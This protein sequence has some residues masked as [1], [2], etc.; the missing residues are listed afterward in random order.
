MT[1]RHKPVSELPGMLAGARRAAG[2]SREE[3]AA[4]A[5]MSKDTL[6]AYEQG[7]RAPRSPDVLHRLARALGIEVTPLLDAAGLTAAELLSSLVQRPLAHFD[8][9]VE[10]YPWPC[11]MNNENLEVV[12]GNA[13]VRALAGVDI[14]SLPGPG[15]RHLL[16]LALAEGIGSRLANL[17]EVLQQLARILKADSVDV[18]GGAQGPRFFASLAAW[19]AKEP[20]QTAAWLF[21]LWNEAVPWEIGR[22]VTFRA[23]WKAS[24]GTVLAFNCLITPWSMFVGIWA[25]DWHPADAA[26]WR[27]LAAQETQEGQVRVR[28]DW[29]GMLEDR[30]LTYGLTRQE[31]ADLAGV[32]ESAIYL[33]ERGLRRPTRG[34]LKA[35]IRH[36]AIDG[37]TAAAIAGALDYEP[38]PSNGYRYICG[39]TVTGRPDL[40][41]L[42]PV[43]IGPEDIRAAVAEHPWPCLVVHA[44][45]EV[46]AASGSAQAM[47][48]EVLAGPGPRRIDAIVPGEPFRARCLNWEEASPRL[49]NLPQG[50][51]SAGLTAAAE[52]GTP[53]TSSPRE[54]RAYTRFGWRDGGDRWFNCVVSSW[55]IWDPF[56]AFDFHPADAATWEWLGQAPVVR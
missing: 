2:L 3:L 30:R 7:R 50:S 6:A 52:D 40:D 15:E 1:A 10:R 21:A 18:A 32:S 5:A 26:T 24:D 45:G 13:A 53:E 46:V 8:A 42:A 38:L 37:A 23:E 11:L 35:L 55:N 34:N 27:W 9:E 16:R 29:P 48:G 39:E 4:R 31:T 17:P 28:S 22:R 44:S 47:F 12:G 41:Q 43:A 20:P 33:W 25:F 56:V 19:L 14:P 36:A 49:L 54:S 51:L